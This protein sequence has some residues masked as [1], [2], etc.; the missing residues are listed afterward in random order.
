VLDCSGKVRLAPAAR[1]GVPKGAGNPWDARVSTTRQGVIA[2]K[3]RGFTFEG[4]AAA[5]D[6]AAC[7]SQ[8]SGAGQYLRATASGFRLTC[9]VSTIG[10]IARKDTARI[11]VFAFIFVFP[12][13][14]YVVLLR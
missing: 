11:G 14:T 1:L 9:A 7:G 2:T 4:K 13:V 6:S 10:I 3:T 12:L 5:A 8:Y